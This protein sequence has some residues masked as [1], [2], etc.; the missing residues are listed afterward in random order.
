MAT[1]PRS[2][3]VS[4]RVGT[5]STGPPPVGCIVYANQRAVPA[6]S[7]RRRLLPRLS[8]VHTEVTVVTWRVDG[9]GTIPYYACALSHYRAATAGRSAAAGQARDPALGHTPRRFGND[10]SG[11]RGGGHPLD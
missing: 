9:S 1:I 6:Q 10:R 4:S 5:G 3:K 2:R 11:M 7:C 8:R